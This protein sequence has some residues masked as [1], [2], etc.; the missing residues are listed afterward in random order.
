MTIKNYL[1]KTLA[2]WILSGS[3]LVSGGCEKKSAGNLEK[4]VVEPAPIVSR[5]FASKP[6]AQ[7]ISI[8]GEEKSQ[9]SVQDKR[10]LANILYGE[11]SNQSSRARKVLGR[12]ILNRVRSHEYPSTLE[13]VVFEKNAFSCIKDRKNENWKQATGT[14]KR[15]EYEEKVYQICNEDAEAVLKGEKL[16]IPDE[17]KIIAYHDKNI[18]YDNLVKKE[19]AIKAKWEKKGK[20]YNGYWINLVP[21][22]EVDRFIVYKKR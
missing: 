18:S 11:A 6:A 8:P 9:Y 13:G 12:V 21:V 20:T 3:A 1:A 14:L 4:K 17:N 5:A 2:I 16:G 7:A 22:C 15:N 19:L 10:L